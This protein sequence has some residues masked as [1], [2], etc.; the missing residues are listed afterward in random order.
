MSLLVTGALAQVS[1]E[2]DYE[3]LSADK[4]EEKVE[5][6]P[7]YTIQYFCGVL[8]PN[9]RNRVPDVTSAEDWSGSPRMPWRLLGNQVQYVLCWNRLW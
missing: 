6:L 9:D 1:S 5:I 8:G 4:D 3:D 7:G 2:N